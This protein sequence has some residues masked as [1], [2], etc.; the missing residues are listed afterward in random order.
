MQSLSRAP[1]RSSWSTRE[2]PLHAT[3]SPGAARSQ[4]RWPRGDRAGRGRGLGE[5]KG[6]GLTSCRTSSHEAI[7]LVGRRET[8]VSGRTQTQVPGRFRER[9]AGRN[10]RG[11][12]RA[13]RPAAVNGRGGLCRE[14]GA[15]PRRRAAGTRQG[16]SGLPGLRASYPRVCPAGRFRRK[17]KC[18]GRVTGNAN[19]RSQALGPSTPATGGNCG[20]EPPSRAR[21]EPGSGR[22][23]GSG[24][25]AEIES[26]AEVGVAGR[27]HWDT[28]PVRRCQRSRDS[29]L[30]KAGIARAASH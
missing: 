24:T 12:G 11:T 5:P 7:A 28:A 29:S 17:A 20:C 16:L 14:A 9:P 25:G 23:L 10:W 21:A 18:A 4:S 30:F 19:L 2:P 3:R 6:A 22:G 8:V 15:G 1:Q 27:V 26:L 13:R